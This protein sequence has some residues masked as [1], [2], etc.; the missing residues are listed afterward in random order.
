MLHIEDLVQADVVF[1][2]RVRPAASIDRV[3]R[4]IFGVE[5]VVAVASAESIRTLAAAQGVVAWAAVQKLR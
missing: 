5:D 2:K 4:T 1:K 3:G